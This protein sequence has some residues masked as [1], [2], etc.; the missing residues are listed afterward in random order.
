MGSDNAEGTENTTM[1][2]QID[3]VK[4]GIRTLSFVTE[5]SFV[6]VVKYKG[7]G[8]RVSMTCYACRDYDSCVKKQ[9]APIHI[10]ELPKTK[11]GV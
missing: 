2:A 6:R 10:S 9:E 5:L 4:R 11:P 1:L 3:E 7:Q 8:V